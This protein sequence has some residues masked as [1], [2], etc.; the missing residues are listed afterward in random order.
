MADLVR[1]PRPWFTFTAC[2]L[3][4]AILYWAQMIL[5]PIA[6]AV[7][8]AFVLAP[9][10][11]ALQRWVGRVP[12]VLAAV[13]LSCV[14]LALV[15]W[16][17]TQQL[18]SLVGE[19]PA[20]QQN[21]HQK[22]R[23][24]RGFSEGGVLDDLRIASE[25][26]AIELGLAQPPPDP[27]AAP[28]PVVSA[29]PA[30]GRANLDTARR[31][32]ERLAAA[33]LVV[34]LVIFM[35]L[36]REPLRGRLVRLFGHGRLVATTRAFD[37]AGWRVSRYLLAQSLV[38]VMFGVSVGIGMYLIGMP[39]PLLWATLAGVARYVPYVGATVAAVVPLL[40]SLSLSGWTKPF[41][42]LGLFTVLELITNLVFETA[43]YAGVAG[44]SQVALLVGV[45]FWG[46]LWG[47]FG[48]LLATP[49]T[50]CLGVMGKHVP[51]LG[52]VSTLI[53]DEPV[54]DPD[55]NYYQRLLAGD[56]AEAIEIVERYVDDDQPPESAYDAI[57]LRALNYAER[58]RIEERLTVQ[59]EREVIETTRELL[60]DAPVRAKLS[61]VKE[62]GD[63]V[64]EPLRVLAVPA[65]GEGDAVALI[66]LADL[67]RN[68][69]IS[70]DVQ[71]A[72]MLTS[73][74]LEMAQREPQCAVLIADLPPSAPSK[75]RYL[76]KRLRARAPD[77]PILVGRWAPPELADENADALLAVGA[78]R[79]ASTL[80]ESRDQLLGLCR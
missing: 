65:N 37:E 39:Y 14:G 40:V 25:K 52:F 72:N 21:I 44:I 12:A 71:T 8:M 73:E 7:L 49:L 38:N 32:L 58:D 78:T 17:V 63:G 77:L 10:V 43:V 27:N 79:V 22:I 31:L 62:E 76:A 57:M 2:A 61:E 64:A 16:L 20:Y 33:G 48:I 15:G 26:I 45:A 34:A 56:K 66:M 18:A 67:L 59:E 35:L 19:I 41:L 42:V 24:I 28:P 55:I 23:D 46:W 6:F 69:P 80:V 74:I 3:V 4:I 5:V 50:V 29:D 54:L 9:V 60:E 11:T 47:P 70:L 51:G 68:A 36:E 53:S 30:N 1:I 13:T 75:S